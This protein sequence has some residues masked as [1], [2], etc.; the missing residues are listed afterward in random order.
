LVENASGRRALRTVT[1]Y[2]PS[3]AQRLR[4]LIARYVQVQK[5]VGVECD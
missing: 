1:G 5:Q 3:V 2:L 4:R